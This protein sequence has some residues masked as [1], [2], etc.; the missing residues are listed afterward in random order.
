MKIKETINRYPKLSVKKLI[1]I[2]KG[3]DIVSF[4]IFD[5][6]IKRDVYKE[7]D[8]FDLIEKRYNATYKDSIDNFRYLRVEAERIA[9]KNSNT[10]EVSLKEIYISIAL[11]DKTYETRLEVLRLLEEEIEYEISYP[12]QLIKE[13]YDYCLLYK[14]KIYII[15]DMYL[16]K[17]LIEKILKKNG[18]ALYKN[19]FLSSEIGLQKKTGN[20]FKHVLKVE[21][22]KADSIIHI[23]DNK[24]NDW[25][26]AKKIG[27]NVVNIAKT[28]TYVKY[29]E[30][31]DSLESRIMWSFLNNR[32]PYIKNRNVAIGYEIYG[33]VL[34]SFVNWL[35]HNIDSTK[36]VLFFSRDC[37]IV[38]RAYEILSSNN[39]NSIYFYASRRS[40]LVPALYVD[41][42]VENLCRL[43]KS[44]SAQFTVR[45]LLRKIGLNPQDYSEIVKKYSLSLDDILIRDHLSENNNFILFYNAI[46]ND[47]K[48]NAEKAYGGFKRYMESLNCTHDLQVVDIG[49]RCT[50]QYCLKNLLKNNYNIQGYY[51]GV[52]EDAFVDKHDFLGLF[53]NGEDNKEKKVFLASMTA[54]IEIFFSALHGSVEGYDIDGTPICGEH[55]CANDLSCLQFI[56]DLQEGAMQFV[57]DFNSS[58]MKNLLEVSIDEALEGI[59]KLG[60]KPQEE[61]LKSFGSFP[62]HMGVGIVKAAEPGPLIGY[63]LHPKKYLYDFSNSNW[64]IAFLKKTLKIKLPYYRIFEILYRHKE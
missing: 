38:K 61:E 59:K 21:G 7:H 3:Y 5:T 56:S 20:L 29:R 11:L 42:S 64:K 35:M 60:T 47:I 31:G 6:L 26:S 19:L 52:R 34:Y 23:G 44:E 2:V 51:L 18:Y 32:I 30:L 16:S 10:E 9:R 40:L 62:F 1:N 36:T 27:F 13:V 41:S 46:Q 48:N 4:D 58:V 45:G 39:Q 12:N 22:V 63:I 8:V 54:L 43:T 57:R 33:P 17:K 49:W 14:K 15:S 50:M 37:Q 28:C 53:L 25:I 24:R 55:E